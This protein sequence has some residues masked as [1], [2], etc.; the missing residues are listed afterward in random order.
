MGK[1]VIDHTRRRGISFR[2]R[3]K[4]TDVRSLPPIFQPNPLSTSVRYSILQQ[5]STTPV[6][7]RPSSLWQHVLP[8][9]TEP[10]V[11]FRRRGRVHCGPEEG[12]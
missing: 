10:G 4:P 8:A 12:G 2:R 1:P 6:S 5:S 7:L 9:A 11:A 3:S